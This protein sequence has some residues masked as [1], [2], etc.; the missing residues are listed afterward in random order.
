MNPFLIK[1]AI[2]CGNTEFQDEGCHDGESQT[3]AYLRM[4]RGI[5]GRTRASSAA[6]SVAVAAG[7]DKESNAPP[8]PPPRVALLLAR[9]KVATAAAVLKVSL[10]SKVQS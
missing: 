5:V 9:G 7:K 8:P 4:E 2:C 1:M 6:V 10:E 3:L